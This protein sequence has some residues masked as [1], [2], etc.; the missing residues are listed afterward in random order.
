MWGD[1]WIYENWLITPIPRVIQELV[2]V[3]QTSPNGGIISKEYLVMFFFSTPKAYIFLKPMVS[4]G[5]P[6]IFVGYN[7]VFIMLWPQQHK[8]IIAGIFFSGSSPQGCHDNVRPIS[9]MDVGHSNNRTDMGG[10]MFYQFYPKKMSSCGNSMKLM[11]N[12]WIINCTRIFR[13]S[14]IR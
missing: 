1:I 2:N 10:D 4:I 9:E 12:C 7:M 8:T 6:L 14:H 11:I 13:Q 5:I 3:I